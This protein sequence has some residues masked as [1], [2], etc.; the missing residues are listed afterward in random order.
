M[1][2]L[3]YENIAA[4]RMIRTAGG[5]LYEWHFAYSIE[6]SRGCCQRRWLGN[7]ELLFSLAVLG[8]VPCL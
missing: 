5:I 7:K 8:T 2:C 1:E 3:I 6:L 4:A